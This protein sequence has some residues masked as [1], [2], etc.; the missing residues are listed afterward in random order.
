MKWTHR[1]AVKDT[2]ALRPAIA[3]AFEGERVEVAR[4]FLDELRA[5]QFVLTGVRRELVS[6]ATFG[7]FVNERQGNPKTDGLLAA[8]KKAVRLGFTLPGL[9]C[10][11]VDLCRVDRSRAAGIR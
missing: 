2:D 11:R 6:I 3:D 8:H 9:L 10:S 7:A 1:Y 4:F 5:G